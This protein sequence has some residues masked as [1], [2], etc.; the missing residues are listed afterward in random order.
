[1]AASI[2]K[3]LHFPSLVST[4]AIDATSTIS[5]A[6]NCAVTNVVAKDGGLAFS[7]LDAL[8]RFSPRT[9][10]ASSNGR[11]FSKNST[12]TD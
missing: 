5:M 12:T 8:C 7:R 2:L 3:G 10:S 9:Q 1:M 11:R 6:K 4:A